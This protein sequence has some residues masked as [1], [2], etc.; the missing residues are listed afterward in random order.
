MEIL[1]KSS[2]GNLKLN[3][4]LQKP[5]K[6]DPRKE[7]SSSKA[8]KKKAKD[9]QDDGKKKKKKKKDPNAPKRAMSGYMFFA[10]MEREVGHIFYIYIDGEIFFWQPIKK[11]SLVNVLIKPGYVV[12]RI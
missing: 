4:Q 11:M 9:G 2:F 3:C 10:Q 6:K 8:T 7:A 5:A 1:V 12:C